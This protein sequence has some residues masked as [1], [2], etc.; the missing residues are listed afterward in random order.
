MELLLQGY[1]IGSNDGDLLTLSTL[2]ISEYTPLSEIEEHTINKQ[3]LKVTDLLVR[4]TR[5]TKEINKTL[6]YIYDNGTIERRIVIE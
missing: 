3:L 4:V 2:S 6:L 1:P 5:E